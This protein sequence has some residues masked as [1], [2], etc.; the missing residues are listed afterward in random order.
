MLNEDVRKSHGD[1]IIRRENLGETIKLGDGKTLRRANCF[2]AALYLMSTVSVST[3]VSAPA[4]S[5]VDDEP[6]KLLD[7]SD[8]QFRIQ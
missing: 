6:Y 2:F 8:S 7:P 4:Y 5:I 3:C 1:E